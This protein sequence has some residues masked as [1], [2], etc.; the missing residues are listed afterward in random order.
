MVTDTTR[1]FSA[2]LNEYLPNELMKEELLK[3]DYLLQKV[4]KD[5]NWLGGTLVVPFEGGRASSISFGSLT[6]STDVAEYTYIRGQITYQ[7]EMWGTL[8]F[9]QRDLWEHGKIS[10][11]NFLQQLPGQID[12]FIDYSKQVASTQMLGSA[13]FA[14]M[15]VTGDASGTIEVDHVERFEIGQ[16]LDVNNGSTTVTAYVRSIN[17]NGGTLGNGSVVLYD[18]RSGGALS[19]AITSAF[20]SSNGKCYHP[21]VLVANTATNKFT[22][23]KDQL[24]SSANGGSSTLFGQTKTSYPYLQAVNVS[25][26]AISATNILEKLFDAYTRVR[27][28]A[29]G[30]ADTFLM[31]YK[32]LG[33]IMK[34][35]ETQKGGFKVSVNSTKAS[36]FGWTEIQI[37][38]VKGELT[39]VGIQEMDDDA[40]FILDWS[41][42]KFYSNGFFKKRVDPETGSPFFAVRAT[43]GYSYLVDVALF[44]D[45]VLLAPSR[46]GII[47]SIPN[48]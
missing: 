11:Q 31:S 47:Y 44:G 38:S 42:I 25:G 41:A 23:L 30:K 15:T 46:C 16:K 4:T 43:T 37:T 28:I 7:P 26:A 45:L 12:A 48:Y 34:S 40:I 35:I 19:T 18:A 9:N 3:R 14:S 13:H 24:L 39:I 10:E 36:M 6:S 5:N 33:S 32:H 29:R 21:G 27:S 1:S 17:L 22:G 20:T 2:M 8:T